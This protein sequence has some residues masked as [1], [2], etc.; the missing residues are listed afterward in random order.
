MFETLPVEHASCQAAPKSYITRPRILGLSPTESH[1]HHCPLEG[2][3]DEPLFLFLGSG[4]AF[5]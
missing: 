2:G 1:K 4:I 3:P 5:A